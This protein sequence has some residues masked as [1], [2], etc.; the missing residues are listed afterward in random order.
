MNE[1]LRA[2]PIVTEDTVRQLAAQV[3]ESVQLRWV[4]TRLQKMVAEAVR[5]ALASDSEKRR[6]ETRNLISEIAA[7]LPGLLADKVDAAVEKTLAAR[8][9]QYLRTPSA[10]SALQRAITEVARHP[11]DAE[12]SIDALVTN[13]SDRLTRTDRAETQSPPQDIRSRIA[14]TEQLT[15]Q[16]VTDIQQKL[17]SFTAEMNRILG[18]QKTG[19]SSES[20]V[21]QEGQPSNEKPLRELL[22]V[23]GSNFEREIEAA[24]QKAFGKLVT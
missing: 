22:Q 6:A 17:N 10:L 16:V 12:D 4:T 24:L 5:S 23:T 19:P 13:L 21:A 11:L 1:H 14:A 20:G 9:D 2:N 7:A 8:I 15:N 18:L 3:A